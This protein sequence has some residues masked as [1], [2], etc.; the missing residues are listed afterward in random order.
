VGAFSVYSWT[1]FRSIRQLT[2]R[3][4]VVCYSPFKLKLSHYTPRRR[5]GRKTNRS[6]TYS[7]SALD[8]GEW[9]ASLPGTALSLGKGPP[10]PIVQEAGWAPELVWTQ[11]VQEKSFGVCRGSNLVRPG[12]SPFR[13]IKQKKTDTGGQQVLKTYRYLSVDHSNYEHMSA[14]LCA[15]LYCAR[16]RNGDGPIKM[17][18][19]L[20]EDSLLRQNSNSE[21][22][23]SFSKI[24]IWWCVSRD[25]CM[26]L[27]L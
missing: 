11:R 23:R 20:S 4:N 15:V 18:Y 12:Y 7:T 22:G 8:G 10:V 3:H 16:Y 1:T 14:F 27:I 25:W 21:S 17:P 5:L 6:Y 26:K 13:K 2:T 24:Y 19:E 9:S